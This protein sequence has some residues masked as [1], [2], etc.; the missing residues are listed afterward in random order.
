MLAVST[1]HKEEKRILALAACVCL[2]I[3]VYNG[4][5]GSK[6]RDA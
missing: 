3:C 4:N 2:C 5:N 6:T 1:A